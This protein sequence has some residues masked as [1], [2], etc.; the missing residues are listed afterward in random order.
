L[1]LCPAKMWTEGF[2][3]FETEKEGDTAYTQKWKWGVYQNKLMMRQ[4]D[5]D[6]M[7]KSVSEGKTVG[8]AAVATCFNS[9]DD[10]RSVFLLS[11]VNTPSCKAVTDYGVGESAATANGDSEGFL[12]VQGSFTL[13]PTDP[14]AYGPALRS[15]DL[16]TS[17]P[18]ISAFHD[19]KTERIPGDPTTSGTYDW[20][21]KKKK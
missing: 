19:V 20:P 7:W 8:A 3:C 6:N 5:E 18:L 13:V 15:K 12:P 14:A 16:Q 17:E 10:I 1:K 9:E 21:D 11:S 2:E 4:Y